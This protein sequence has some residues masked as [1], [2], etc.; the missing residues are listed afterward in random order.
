MATELDSTALD[1]EPPSSAEVLGGAEDTEVTGRHQL[2]RARVGGR[3]HI[4]QR[5][6]FSAAGLGS[7]L[8]P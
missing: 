3:D 2:I 4:C 1:S 7:A 8:L 5:P 6:V